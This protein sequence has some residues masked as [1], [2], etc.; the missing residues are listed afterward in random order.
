MTIFTPDHQLRKTP[1]E[2]TIAHEIEEARVLLERAEREPDPDKKTEV[3][4]EA[5]EQLD[6]CA[7]EAVSQAE[8][9]L[10]ANL[11]ISHT[12]RLMEQLVAVK[13]IS[14]DTWY[15]Y[16]AFF[17]Y[18]LKDEVDLLVKEDARFAGNYERFKNTWS[19]EFL[20]KHGKK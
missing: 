12:R 5:I 14:M 18:F 13:S 16:G 1:L 9:T 19:R 15:G 8:I 11:R 2:M 6:F 4:L 17:L 10:V 3:L 20:A 7:A